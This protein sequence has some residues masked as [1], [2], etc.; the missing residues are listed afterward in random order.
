M[1]SVV[2]GTRDGADHQDQEGLYASH[3]G[4]VGGGR[5]EQCA[6]LVVGLVHTKGVE[7]APGVEEQHPAT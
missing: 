1:T 6:G 5:V 3:P 4:D 7:D 2:D